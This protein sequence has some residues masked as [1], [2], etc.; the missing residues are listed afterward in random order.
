MFRRSRR[1]WEIE[2]AWGRLVG[3]I[4]FRRNLGRFWVLEPSVRKELLYVM[5]AGSGGFSEVERIRIA[6]VALG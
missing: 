3:R 4:R 2:G 5:K 1:K 6:E